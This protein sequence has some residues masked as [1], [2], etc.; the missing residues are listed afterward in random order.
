MVKLNTLVRPQT[1]YDPPLVPESLHSPGVLADLH[2]FPIDSS[3]IVK[4]PLRRG[5]G[6]VGQASM[7]AL[8]SAPKTGLFPQ[9]DRAEFCNSLSL[10]DFDLPESGLWFRVSRVRIPSLTF[11]DDKS[12]PIHFSIDDSTSPTRGPTSRPLTQG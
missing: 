3:T 8:K 12:I 5:S 4:I 7:M 2:C 10:K 6:R 11:G 1:G 9:A